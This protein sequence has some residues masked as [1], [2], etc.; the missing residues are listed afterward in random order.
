M[1]CPHC[2]GELSQGDVQRDVGL[3]AENLGERYAASKTEAYRTRILEDV[4]TRAQNSR[5]MNRSLWEMARRFEDYRSVYDCARELREFCQSM[6]KHPKKPRAL[7]WR[8]KLAS[9]ER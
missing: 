2:Q 6:G 3:E 7:T 4:K 5:G 9:K 1:K 8:E